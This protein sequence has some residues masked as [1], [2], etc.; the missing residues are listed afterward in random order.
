MPFFRTIVSLVAAGT[1]AAQA[2]AQTD[3]FPNAAPTRGAATPVIVEAPESPTSRKA[4]EAYA[5]AIAL[6]QDGDLPGA[7][8]SYTT[9]IAL[10]PTFAQAHFERGVLKSQT[11]DLNGAIIDLANAASRAPRLSWLRSQAL[12]E[13]ARALAA[14][15]DFSRAVSDA[16]DS[17][18]NRPDFT[19]A[20]ALRAMAQN[21][22]GQ[23][24]L[25]L[26]DANDALGLEPTHAG[27]RLERARAFIAL[28][29]PDPAIAD[30]GALIDSLEGAAPGSPDGVMLVS[31]LVARAKASDS[32][33]HIRPAIDDFGAAIALDPR[34]YDALVGRAVS[35]SRLGRHGEAVADCQRAIACAPPFT[36]GDTPAHRL[37]PRLQEFAGQS[38]ATAAVSER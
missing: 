35:L 37:L 32:I 20:L 16:S 9:V 7:I 1:L 11:K 29:K 21:E 30:L 19:D 10:E 8:Q 26:D 33:G 18:T 2:P 31:A 23:P 14:T 25:A 15:L 34:C 13:R 22:L 36:R 27:A 24:Y 5:A 4:G 3:I 38:S 17:L 28:R 6:A 12:Y